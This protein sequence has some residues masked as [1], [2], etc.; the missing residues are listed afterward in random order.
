MADTQASN[1]PAS[2]VP[3]STPVTDEAT[4]AVASPADDLQPQG[5]MG[6]REV[7]ATARRRRLPD[8]RP[9]VAFLLLTLFGSLAF[10][11]WTDPYRYF[12]LGMAAVGE[13][14]W[15][16]VA[17]SAAAL[18]EHPSYRLQHQF[19][20]ASLRMREGRPE[21]AL[22]LA[23]AAQGHPDVAVEARVLAGEA[24]YQLG[25][26]GNAKLYWEDALMLDEQC[27]AAHQ[28]LGVLYFDLGAMDNAILHLQAVSHLSPEDHRPDRLMGL[29]NRDYER[30]EVAIPHYLESLRRAP[31]QPDAENVRLEL[32]EC[33]I[34]Q[35]E[36]DQAMANLESCSDSARKKRLVA[37]CLMNMGELDEARELARQALQEQPDQLE[38]LQLNADIALIDGESERAA[39]WL[40]RGAQVDPY[41]HGTRTQLAQVLG[42]M[43]L[44]EESDEHSRRADELQKLWERF[45][46]LQIDAINRMTDAQVR[47]EIGTLARQLGKPELAIVW[48]KAALAIDPSL[49]DAAQALSEMGES[50][51]TE[52][53]KP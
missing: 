52:S 36:F 25:A 29:I 20:N 5:E 49:S 33:Q 37:R 6:N 11:H 12:E 17:A 40:R 39:R 18:Q 14:D 34:K 13:N 43:G 7:A 24:A 2:A 32:A 21:A 31:D 35:R 53:S 47:Y 23:I 3:A 42:R 15:D 50:T 4:T 45:S 10:Q 22:P 46:D 26:A 51:A 41:D 44:D 28:W 16:Q 27:V 30:P 8:P 38:V 9:V 48:F 1:V 19:L